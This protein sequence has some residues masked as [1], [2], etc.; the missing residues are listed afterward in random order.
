MGKRGMKPKTIV[1]DGEKFKN[2]LPQEYPHSAISQ[3]I[4]GKSKSFLTYAFKAG[5]IKNDD[6]ERLCFVFNLNKDD[7]IIKEEEKIKQEEVSEQKEETVVA[8]AID[9]KE[10]TDRL[11]KLVETVGEL[12]T[13][14][15]AMATAQI[16]MQH[17]LDSL[18]MTT[19]AINEGLK[20]NL[21]S[22]NTEM[23][24]SNSSL[25][26]IKGRLKD[27]CDEETEMRRIA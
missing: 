12:T 20:V 15:K 13:I 19:F 4:L 25:N 21:D 26:V 17:K 18:E 14:M 8:E 22:I 9:V 7:Y 3:K 10:I 5:R 27:L 6:L 11:D 24:K 16:N 23:A 1:I 2:D